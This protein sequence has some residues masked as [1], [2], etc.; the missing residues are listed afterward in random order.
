[1]RRRRHAG[2]WITT[3]S[4]A[5]SLHSWV[6]SRCWWNC[7][8]PSVRLPWTEGVRREDCAEGAAVA[9]RRNLFNNQLN[10]TLPSELGELTNLGY[11]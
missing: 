10:G 7:E 2:T 8:C 1:M 3:I 11:L 9:A 6:N 5:R 4:S